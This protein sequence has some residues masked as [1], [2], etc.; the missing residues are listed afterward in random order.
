MNFTKKKA[1]FQGY[2]YDDDENR[3]DSKEENNEDD[4]EAS[5]Y[6][7]NST[8]TDST[9]FI[10]QSKKISQIVATSKKNE[11]NWN[12]QK[13]IYKL[14]EFILFIISLLVTTSSLWVSVWLLFFPEYQNIN[15]HFVLM[16]NIL[17]FGDNL[18]PTLSTLYFLIEALSFTLEI[19]QGVV[20]LKVFLIF[21]TADNATLEGYSKTDHD[22]NKVIIDNL[23]HRVIVRKK[24][25][26]M[27]TFLISY[28]TLINFFVFTLVIFPKLFCGIYID[29]KLNKILNT[30]EFIDEKISSILNLNYTAF[31]PPKRQLNI[32]PNRNFAFRCCNVTTVESNVLS[33][34]DL[35]ECSLDE[36]F[37]CFYS[38]AHFFLKMLIIIFFTT[39]IFK[40]LFQS[41]FIINL[42]YLLI[43]P[44]IKKRQLR[45]KKMLKTYE[46]YKNNKHN[47]QDKVK[48]IIDKN[49]RNLSKY[50]LS[51]SSTPELSNLKKGNNQIHKVTFN[52]EV[53]SNEFLSK[54]DR[55]KGKYENSSTYPKITTYPK[56]SI[57]N[58]YYDWNE[59][60]KLGE[61]SNKD[62]I[63][64]SPKSS[65]KRA[66]STNDEHFLDSSW[67]VAAK[68]TPNKYNQISKSIVRKT[69]SD[70]KPSITSTHNNYEFIADSKWP[71]EINMID[72][73][74]NEKVKYEENRNS[75]KNYISSKYNGEENQT[76][77]RRTYFTL[78]NSQPKLENPG[79]KFYS[80]IAEYKLK[81][82]QSFV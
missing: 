37:K 76:E 7:A 43:H 49:D 80:S 48:A 10:T 52:S 51:S 68:N 71:N 38:A 77:K 35:N 18:I 45:E 67:N 6:Q 9:E 5:T 78:K 61:Y 57:E 25:K 11:R 72:V 81:K 65:I 4:E 2:T 14:T 3:N 15:A 36:S 58:D 17:N 22:S 42:R 79:L 82:R 24:L 19:T 31:F 40:F 70:N 44:L 53:K 1:S 8:D 46:N 29:I 50:I 63:L 62:T 33:L 59:T 13:M 27:L 47:F 75:R 66:K 55:I 64:S 32:L 26:S 28:E 73:N 41:F 39:S 74:N 54:S 56:Y 34:E 16:K 60:S 20:L 21:R 23:R 12:K 30:Q 69:E